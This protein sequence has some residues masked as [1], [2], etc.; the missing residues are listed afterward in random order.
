M[1]RA[2]SFINSKILDPIKKDS[3]SDYL[4][5]WNSTV[6]Y[7]RREGE[8]S[9]DCYA[10]EILATYHP[11]VEVI[12]M[13]VLATKARGLPEKYNFDRRFQKIPSKIRAKSKKE[14]PLTHDIDLVLKN[15]IPHIERTIK[16]FIDDN[17]AKYIMVNSEEGYKYAEKLGVRDNN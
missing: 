1:E 16:P 6:A 10:D 9:I 11:L 15:S 14:I 3:K 5:L 4:C 2:F 12:D 8:F 7:M 13:N 17:G